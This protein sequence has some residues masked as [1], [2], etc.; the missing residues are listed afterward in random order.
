[1]PTCKQC[2]TAF[3]V[4]DSDR[5]FYARMQVP[6][7]EFC[8][9]CRYQQRLVF[10]NER[11][12]YMRSCSATG[13]KIVS[14][15]SEDKSHPPV[16]SQRYWWSDN[17]DPKDYGR[18]FDFSRPF[19]EQW[20]ELYNTVPQLAL[21]NSSSENSEFT[22]QCEKNKDCYLLTCANSC[23][24]C[25]HGMWIQ[26][27]RNVMDCLYISKS[28]FCYQ[29][30]NGERCNRCT[31]SQNLESCSECHF[32]I[33]CIGCS[34]CVGCVN[35]R[36]KKFHIFN[37]P[38]SP[39]EYKKKVGSLKLSTHA[40]IQTLLK[41]MQDFKLESVKKYYEGSKTENFSGDY[42]YE[43]KNAFDCFNCRYSENIQH[44]QDAWRARNCH[45]L[46]ET[47]QNDFCYSVEG[48]AYNNNALFSMKIKETSDAV[49]C[50]H[51]LFSNHLFGCVG[52]KN[53]R[54]CVLNKQY[55]REDYENLVNKI[56]EHMRQTGEWGRY[57]PSRFSHFGYNETVAQEYFPLNQ[58]EAIAKGF[59]WSNYK[60]PAPQADKIIPAQ[61]LPE[62]IRDVPDD[63][64]NWA[65]LCE[66]TEKPF[67]IIAQELQFYR[68]MDL[69]L[70]H[71]HPDERHKRR[72]TLRNP[73]KLFGKK[74][75]ECGMSIQTTYSHERPERVYCEGCYQKAVY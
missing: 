3:E 13:E 57:F 9:S 34:D 37:Q 73:R 14:V 38:Y 24:S 71:L 54:Y 66:A 11:N 27:C 26:S 16:Y 61:R 50:S 25:F 55:T 67:K 58:E 42:V 60:K 29:V 31:F 40:G 64:L 59:Q 35:L 32:S 70:P 39:E 19:F 33:N 5:Q 15:Y 72:M 4:T 10:R 2:S 21:N 48:S 1:M 65:L 69:P 53:A 6:E 18:D 41:R 7:P 44:C 46:T 28:D 12:L 49:Y 30:V 56:I 52:L 45:D 23:E 63:V 36:N 75:D 68:Q 74:C 17:W 43:V 8:P 51:C 20:A 47:L 62:S 22:N